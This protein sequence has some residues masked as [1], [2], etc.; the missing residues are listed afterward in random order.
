MA[1]AAMEDPQAALAQLADDY[2]RQ[3]YP[4]ARGELPKA[5]VVSEIFAST[6]EQRLGTRAA[7]VLSNPRYRLHVFTTR[8]RHLLHR[9]G[10]L[11]AALGYMGAYAANAVHRRALG[12]W[13]ERVVF[14]DPRDALPFSLSDFRSRQVPLE[15]ANLARA[16]L[17]SCSIPFA[18]DAVQ[19]VPGGPLGS[20][21][22]GGITDYHLHLNYAAMSEGLVLYPHFQPRV[23]PGWL[24]KAWRHRHRASPMLD[25]L[26]V[27]APHP[28]FIKRLPNEKLPDRQDFRDMRDDDEGRE[29]VWRIA[30]AES[31]RLAEDLERL[32]SAGEPFEAQPLP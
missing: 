28:H 30:L 19:D 12:G 3:R 25:N 21:W 16:V 11:R 26:V 13:L 27:L 15:P 2:V 17:A 4:H 22:D 20:Y 18:L 10:G 9:A 32:V 7:E 8:G 31:T 6:L 5:R 1:C 14:S 24:D 23:V 29:R